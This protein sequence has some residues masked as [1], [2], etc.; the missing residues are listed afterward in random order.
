MIDFVTAIIPC[1]H[2]PSKLIDGLVMSFD[3]LGAQQWV[4]NKR[5]SV[6]GS[7]SAKIQ[8]MTWDDKRIW[9]SGNPVKF[10]QGHNIFGSDDLRYIMSKFFVELVSHEELGL[11]PDEQELKWVRAGAYD[12]SRVDFNLSWHLDSKD[13][14]LS[15]LRAA[16]H[17]ANLRNR[18]PGQFTGETLYFGKNSRHWSLKCY[19]KGHEIGAKNH[20]LPKD[21]QIPE[22]MDWANRALRLEL[23]FRSRFLRDTGLFRVS[24]WTQDTG[25]ELL[26]SCIKD[27]LQISDN[28]TLP[29]DVLKALPARLKGYYALWATGEDL[30]Q[31]MSKSSFYRYRSQLLEYGI[32]ITVVQAQERNNVIPLVRYLEALPASI[33]DWAYQKGL[34]A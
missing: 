9:I 19:S 22:L 23:V 20:Q 29:D 6:E 10:L 31:S 33:P 14:V 5:V 3:R 1:K 17:C 8:V 4:T 2:D 12:V 18:G 32:D 25:K 11:C 27:D 15:W 16:A 7:H 30:R 26:L 28:M 13:A 24:K 34:V 21:L